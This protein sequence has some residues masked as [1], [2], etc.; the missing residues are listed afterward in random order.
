[1]KTLKVLTI[2]TVVLALGAIQ[3]ASAQ[4]RISATIGTP[5][6]YYEPAP[7]YYEEPA[8]VVVVNRPIV[9]HRPVYERRVVVVNRPV[10][11]GRPNYYRPRTVVVNRPAYYRGNYHQVKYHG[12]GHNNHGRYR[13]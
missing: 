7:V 3:Q 1:M 4:I 6:R 2:A 8:P 11:Y 10:Y 12:H 5:V 13:D 9:Y